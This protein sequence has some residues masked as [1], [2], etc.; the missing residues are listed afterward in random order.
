MVLGIWECLGFGTPWVSRGPDSVDGQ[1]TDERPLLNLRVPAPLSKAE[2]RVLRRAQAL[3]V[4]T[5]PHVRDA[6]G[7]PECVVCSSLL[8]RY[9]ADGL[10][11]T[12]K[13]HVDETAFATAVVSLSHPHDFDGGLVVQLGAHVASRRLVPLRQGDLVMHRHDVLHGV[14]VRAGT[15]FS[16]IMWFAWDAASCEEGTH[17][18]KLAAAEA[19]DAVAQYLLGRDLLFGA[20]RSSL[21]A[22]AEA[23]SWLQRSATQ[24]CANSQLNVGKRLAE[25]GDL[26]A[27]RHWWRQAAAQ[28]SAEA[29]YNLGTSFL[30]ADSAPL[31]LPWLRLAAQQGDND[32]SLLLNGC[33]EFRE[34]CAA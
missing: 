16:L 28:G 26:L 8:R 27:A 4:R 32:A 30:R 34:P 23:W 9:R 11:S 29:Q 20:G 17:P 14:D 13:P 18:W 5:T 22:E 3:W 6:F 24:G 15:R 12:L 7:C 21:A 10:R 19:G 2:G 33:Y 1:P 31:A 25:Q